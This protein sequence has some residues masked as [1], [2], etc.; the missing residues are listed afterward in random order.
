MFKPPTIS[1]PK[2]AT[3]SFKPKLTN[4]HCLRSHIN[5]FNNINSTKHVKSFQP[6]N[7]SQ[8]KR[9]SSSIDVAFYLT[10][11]I[12][13]GGTLT[14]FSIKD[15]YSNANYKTKKY[16]D[17][18]ITIKVDEAIVQKDNSVVAQKDILH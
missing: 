8:Q 10:T 16:I 12:F 2:N 9:Y 5:K 1:K 15:N 6:F 4:H 14:Y 13:L 7:N 17:D 3:S 18:K 11:G